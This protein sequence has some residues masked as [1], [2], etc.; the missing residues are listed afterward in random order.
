MKDFTLFVE[1]IQFFDEYRQKV[2]KE[3]NLDFDDIDLL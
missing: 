1:S 2:F 3:W